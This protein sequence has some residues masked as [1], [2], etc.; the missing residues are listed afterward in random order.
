MSRQ[1]QSEARFLGNITKLFSVHKKGIIEALD[2][3]E[4]SDKSKKGG[5]DA[6]IFDLIDLLNKSEDYATTSSCSGRVSVFVAKPVETKSSGEWLLVTH[7][8]IESSD[9][10]I[11]CLQNIQDYPENTLISFKFEPL[12]IHVMCRTLQAARSLHHLTSESG[13][14]NS[15]IT[16]G[17]KK[18]TVA[19]RNTILLDVPLALSGK[20]L[21]NE[22]YIKVL[23][24]LAN[25]KFAE[26]KNRIDRLTN[27][28]RTM[29]H[30]EESV[31]V[32]N[33]DN[34]Q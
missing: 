26:N 9:E 31:N 1:D 19:I 5:V 13:F 21:V 30:P 22:D 29:L 2:Q 18:I 10:V 32:T 8:P 23:V 24:Q 25:E 4:V 17:K 3:P 33:D 6:P 11:Q 34:T 27:N 7:D 28:L 20:L 15:G 16:I 14:R 12:I